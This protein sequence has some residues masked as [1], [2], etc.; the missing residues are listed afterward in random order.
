ME[1]GAQPAAY[2]EGGE[3]MQGFIGPATRQ[4]KR[5]Q[6]TPPA[7]GT[8]VVDWAVDVSMDLPPLSER[9]IAL[10]TMTR[11]QAMTARLLR[12][13]HL[14]MAQW[15]L[16]PEVG[17]AVWSDWQEFETLVEAGS[18]AVRRWIEGRS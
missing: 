15:T 2:H 11:G 12:Q 17:H 10:D 7:D 8:V 6:F 18:A 16:R 3:S 4:V 5:L 14:E 1:P 13:H 9:D